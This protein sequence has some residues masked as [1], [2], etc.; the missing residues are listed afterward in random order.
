MSLFITGAPADM[1][2]CVGNE[3]P[4]KLCFG[5]FSFE[6]EV[7]VYPVINSGILLPRSEPD[8]FGFVGKGRNRGDGVVEV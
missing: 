3:S 4:P 1:R 5:G 7:K 2:L 8:N 6:D